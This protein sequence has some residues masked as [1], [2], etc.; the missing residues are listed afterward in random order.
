MCRAM[1]TLQN[2]Q[3]TRGEKKIFGPIG[4]SLFLGAALV[5]EGSNGVGKTSLLKIIAGI[6]KPS[7]GEILWN[8]ENIENFRSDFNGD[9]QFIGHNNFLKQELSV[10]E[11]LAFYAKLHDT[12]MLL[13]A[14]LRFFKLEEFAHQKVKNLSAGWQ[15]R[16]QLAR[17]LACP[18]TIWVLDEPSN[19]LDAAGKKLLRGLIETQLENGKMVLLSTHDGEFLDVGAR[20]KL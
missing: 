17:L 8:N 15:K 6:S 5:V 1:L 3:L 12:Q 4:L 2:L 11:N 10:L 20:L 13:A 18:A 19:N 16:V 9:L 7:G 14:A